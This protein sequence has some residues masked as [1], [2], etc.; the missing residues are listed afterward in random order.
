MP[1]NKI[2]EELGKKILEYIEFIPR[3]FTT[4]WLV[5][6]HPKKTFNS[7]STKNNS[8]KLLMPATFLGINI[9]LST[10]I[11]Y[12]IGY[13]FPKF[14]F[15]P[16]WLRS[17]WGDLSVIT[18]R[19]LLGYLILLFL[20][21]WLI[22]YREH[23]SFIKKAFPMLCYSSALYIVYVIV[24]QFFLEFIFGEF[25]YDDAISM[26]SNILIMTPATLPKIDYGLIV[27]LLLCGIPV[28]TVFCWWVWLL[29]SGLKSYNLNSPRRTKIALIFGIIIFSVTNQII[30]FSEGR[31]INSSMRRGIDVI[32]KNNIDEEISKG[33][34]SFF[35]AITDAHTVAENHM[36]PEAVRYY[37]IMK[38]I[39][40]IISLPAFNNDQKLVA[41]ILSKLKERKFIEIEQILKA[42]RKN[43]FSDLNLDNE[44]DAAK[45]FRESPD[46]VDLHDKHPILMYKVVDDPKPISPDFVVIHGMQVLRFPLI[47]AGKLISIFP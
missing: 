4:L 22:G 23:D 44:L 15:Q 36:M 47:K 7:L 18:L 8:L 26:L 46:Y 16:P 41:N 9:L 45:S 28:L 12:M 24:Y 27:K 35:K 3:Y 13:T 21:K 19:Y 10:V 43:I 34:S 20:I 2:D 29:Y 17:Y 38:K 30:Q 14:F 40:F 25:F 39:S 31:F 11:G 5:I 32:I 6:A 1:G 37:F 33:P 42:N